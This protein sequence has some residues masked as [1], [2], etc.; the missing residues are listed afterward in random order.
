MAQNEE[1]PAVA[2]R[3]P[4][5]EGTTALF[6]PEES[7][8]EPPASGAISGAGGRN[9]SNKIVI[10]IWVT[11]LLGGFSWYACALQKRA[12][13]AERLLNEAFTLYGQQEFTRSTELLRQSAELGNAWAQL[14]YGERLK[15]GFYAE[16]NA[17]EAVKWLRKSAGKGCPEAFYQLGTCY[18]NGEGVDRDLS[19]AESWYRK[20]LNDPGS[21]YLAQG[22]LDR[23]ESLKAKSGEGM[24]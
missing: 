2:A 15:N 23:I 21:A 11:L 19:E 12:A 3:T 7:R 9:G 10:V 14:Y 16:P 20:A 13:E 24:D 22:A 5:A 17:A 1:N 18:E 4:G 8:K 6:V